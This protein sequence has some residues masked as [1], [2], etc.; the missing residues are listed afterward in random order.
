MKHLFTLFLMLVLSGTMFGQYAVHGHDHPYCHHVKQAMADHN[1]SILDIRSELL[2]DYDV[3]FYFLDIA[4]ENNSTY[5]E[6]NVTIEAGVTSV[7]LDTLAFELIADMTVD[8]VRINGAGHNFLHID[9]EVFVPLLSPLIQGEHF[10]FQ[11]FYHGTPPQGTFFSGM[12]TGYS[13]QFQKN[14]TWSLSEPYAA[15]D[16]WPT[17]QDLTD[18]ADSSWVFITTS[19]ENM[20]G[21]QGLLTAITPMPENKLRYEWKS[22]YSIAYYLISVAVADYQEY[23]IYSSPSGLNG[24]SILIQNFIY[25]HPDCLPTYQSGIDN[26]VEFVELF[27]DLYSLYPFWEEKYGHCLT[28]LGGGMEHQTMSTMGG[29]WF[30]LVA[31]ELGHMWFGD[32]VTCATWSDIWINEG[33]ATYSD[34]LAHEK[35]AGPPWPQIWLEDVHESVLSQPGGSVYVPPEQT[36]NILRIFDGRLSYNK[37]ASIVHMIRFELQDDTVFFNVLKEFQEIFKDSVATGLDFRDVLEDVS[38]K[39]FTDFFDQWYFGE[40]YPL[41]E[42]IWNQDAGFFNMNVTQMASTTVTP[43]FS[44]LMPYRISF[45]DGTDTTLLLYQDEQVKNFSVPMQKT[46]TGIE[47]DPENW[48]LDKV[49]GISTAVDELDN[50]M[51]FTLGPNPAGELFR[52]VLTHPVESF[53]EIR[54]MDQTGR[55]VYSKADSEEQTIIETSGFRAGT[56]IVQILGQKDVFTRKLIVK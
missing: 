3:T 13:S 2:F 18:K 16:W 52:I 4:V 36:G 43:F 53:Y 48:V 56:Y 15:K 11:V 26:T 23:N 19:E 49:T 54:I 5:V 33:F 46:I 24:D 21:S 7:T 37:G 32:N 40:G 50:F 35:V 29:F 20:A 10:A 25:D 44:M 55:V 31:H 28:P 9:D 1:R 30:G 14:V 27:S 12:S 42:I 47:V 41:Y 17:K 45:D 51:H 8:S 6:G 34:Y 38:G 22:R 39:D